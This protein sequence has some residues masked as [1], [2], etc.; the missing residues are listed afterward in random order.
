MQENGFWV[1]DEGVLCRTA[2]NGSRTSNFIEDPVLAP[3][4]K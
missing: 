1:L 4:I 3:S 2:Y